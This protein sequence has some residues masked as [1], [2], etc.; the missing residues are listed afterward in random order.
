MNLNNIFDEGEKQTVALQSF[1]HQPLFY[2]PNQMMLYSFSASSSSGT[3]QYSRNAQI[4]EPTK[5][6]KS[7]KLR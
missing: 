5:D 4:N 2:Q 7:G 6:T 1:P 3:L